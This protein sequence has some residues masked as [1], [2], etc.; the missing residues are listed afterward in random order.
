[1]TNNVPLQQSAIQ[2]VG[3]DQ[4]IL[5]KK[6]PVFMPGPYQILCKVESVGLCFS[7]LKLVKQFSEH[8][9][10]KP[11]CSGID[12]SIL[13]EIPSYVPSEKPTVPG[14][15]T[16]VRIVALGSEVEGYVLDGRYLV[17][18]DYRWLPTEGSNASFGY[19]FEGG[20]QQ[21]VLMDTR[22]ITSPEGE[23]M[24]IPAS[25]E[26]S[27]SSIA[28]VE[29]W[30]CVE[31]SYASKERTHLD[32]RGRLLVVCEANIDE[33]ALMDFFSAYGRPDHILMLA[34]KW[35]KSNE[36]TNTEYISSLDAIENNGMNDIIYFGAN[37]ETVELLFPKLAPH[38]LINIVQCGARFGR[39]VRT[40]IGRVHYGG[41]RITGTAGAHPSDSMNNVPQS[42]EIRSGDRISIVGAGGPMGMMHVIR[43]ICQGIEGISI[44]ASDLND[45]RLEAL[46]RI[47][48]PLAKSR[49]VPFLAY[50]PNVNPIG[51]SFDYIALMVPAPSLVSQAIA[52]CNNNGIINIFAGIPA[53]VT[54]ELDLDAYIEKGLYSVGTSGSVLEDMKT[55]LHKVEVS[56]QLD[57]NLSVAAISGLDG[58]IEG[59]RAVERQLFAGKI[60][61]YPSCEGLGLMQLEDLAEQLP[62]VAAKL[63]NGIWTKEAEEM[64]LEHYNQLGKE[65]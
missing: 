56:K 2:L 51:G 58:A 20:L 34:N 16:A 31:D 63:S 54:A 39:P 27:A 32:P 18:T 49:G 6:K 40:T 55:V 10:K 28:L 25:T 22:V 43:N 50:N 61:V 64:L 59:I 17:Q 26:V 60:I 4:L 15:E 37:A 52:D 24:L 14:H 13:D 48:E 21:Y 57:T 36:L 44:Y 46:I 19:N 29:P 5:N 38:G 12:P 41:I 3:P 53:Q 42:G 23:S 7:D 35:L 65:S 47:A 1:M 9:R 30:A 11:I 62:D 33:S 8:P 45:E